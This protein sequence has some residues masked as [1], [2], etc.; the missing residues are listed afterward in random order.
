MFWQ[1][2][3]C[4]KLSEEKKILKIGLKLA[5]IEAKMHPVT[6]YLETQFLAGSELGNNHWNN[7]IVSVIPIE[8]IRFTLWVKNP[9]F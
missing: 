9:N 1:K 5:E 2:S 4:H 3:P 6:L 8:Y 7:R